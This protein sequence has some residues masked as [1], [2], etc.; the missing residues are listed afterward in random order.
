V[1]GLP[2][3]PMGLSPI[4]HAGLLMGAGAV[5]TCRKGL[6]V[7]Y[8]HGVQYGGCTEQLLSIDSC[9]NWKGSAMTADEFCTFNCTM[10]VSCI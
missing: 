1:S 5:G 2:L 9:E 7:A 6:L 3:H 8:V 4:P 10:L